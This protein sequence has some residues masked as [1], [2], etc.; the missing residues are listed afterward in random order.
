MFSFRNKNKNNPT[1]WIILS[2]SWK[3]KNFLDIFKVDIMVLVLFLLLS[4][5]SIFWVLEIIKWEKQLKIREEKIISDYNKINEY[6][7][8]LGFLNWL[9]VQKVDGEKVIKIL[10]YLDEINLFEYE[11]EFDSLK[12]YFYVNLPSLWQD[13]LSEFISKWI[14]M[15]V[16]NSSRTNQT[17]RI[18]EEGRV[19]V[20]LIFN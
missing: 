16:L 15:R 20:T 6:S 8:T 14:D 3:K 19:S 11:L 7:K 9:R 2:D 18:K 1:Q 5:F 4:W 13:Q 10:N 17:I 12:K